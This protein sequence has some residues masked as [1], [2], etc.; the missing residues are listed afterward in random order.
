[1]ESEE[2]DENN[3]GSPF[4]KIEKILINK[5]GNKEI[6]KESNFSID[7]GADSLDMVEIF[8]EVEKTFNIVIEKE[9]KQKIV[10][11]ID[12]LDIIDGKNN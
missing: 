9:Q 8:I 1:M 7:L 6:T 12:L 11:V 3:I 2:I 4:Y 5:F 10:K